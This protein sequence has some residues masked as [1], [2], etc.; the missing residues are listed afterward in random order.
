M[1]QPL[2]IGPGWSI[3]GTWSVG[4]APAGVGAWSFNGANDLIILDYS[5]AT[6]TGDTTFEMWIRPS[7]SSTSSVW[8]LPNS[9]VSPTNYKKLQWYLTGSTL[10]AQN[11]PY[12]GGASGFTPI[13]TTLNLNAWNYVC[14]A[15]VS[16]VA[17]LYVNGIRIGSSTASNYTYRLDNWFVGYD[18][19]PTPDEF[20][21]GQLTNI[22]L[23]NADIYNLAALPATMPVPTGQLTVQ[24]STL[25]LYTMSDSNADISNETD[26]TGNASTIATVPPT[27]VNSVPGPY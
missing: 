16:G 22:R 9:Y 12:G 6:Y 4:S 20:F 18:T 8:W 17:I 19:Q 26:S 27:W 25:I 14:F 2:T 1:A 5:P 15:V 7:G 10:T 13:S 21:T 24:G 11:I 23:S 3:S